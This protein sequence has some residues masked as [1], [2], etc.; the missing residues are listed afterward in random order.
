[1]RKRGS[2]SI[3]LPSTAS[4]ADEKLGLSAAAGWASV[5][6]ASLLFSG[7]AAFGQTNEF[8][9][10]PLAGAG[11]TIV[12]S[13]FGGQILGFDIDQNGTEGLL[14][15]YRDLSSGNVLAAVETFDQ[16][17]GSILKVV[18]ETMTKDD[19]V[20]LGVVGSSVGLV[21]HEHVQGI[22]QVKRTFNTLNSLSSNVITGFWTPPIGT[23]H[24]IE[25]TGVSRN[26]GEPQVAVFAIDNS[27]SFIP[28][29]FSSNVAANTFGP[30]VKITDST[31]F[32]S[33]PPP[34]AFDPKADQAVLGGGPGCFGCLPVIGLVDLAHGTF[35]EFTGTGFGFING[36]A[37]DPADGIACTTTEDDA[38]VEF[39]DLAAQTGFSVELP[40]SGGLQFYS[41]AD[42]EY[43][44][45]H[46]VFLVAQPNSSSASSGSSIYVYDING[47]LQET[48][49]GFSFSNTFNVVPAHI[50]LHPSLR[51]G[52]V[53]G[54]S[55][56]VNQLQSFTY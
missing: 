14:S 9:P 38:G 44:P 23:S 21:E 42:V 10:N 29:V 35:T 54:P 51:T 55:A 1:M 30:V 16:T 6:L 36:L 7:A 24:L 56:N 28:W 5:I 41:G 2:E 18:A 39:Y 32:G 53:D 20:T 8:Q 31:N 48:I 40:G 37:V 47:N 45:M 27:G 49:N 3:I 25:P 15:E 34:I 33:V 50:A 26:Q 19:F 22:L 17:T 13:K 4:R 46:K 12:H 43:D 52:Y 11:D